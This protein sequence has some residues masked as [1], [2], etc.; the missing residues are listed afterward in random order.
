LKSVRG[1]YVL[2]IELSKKTDVPVGKLGKLHLRKGLYVYVGSAQNTLE[3]R[4]ERHRRREKRVFW[5]I[6]YLLQNPNAKIV[7]VFYQTAAKPEECNI[8]ERIAA[9]GEPVVG[10]GCSDCRCKSHLFRVEAYGFLRGFMQEYT[11][12]NLSASF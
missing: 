11:L 2:I 8:A 1:V 4:I 6:D 3:K 12:P 10:F 5:H 7:K 9:Q